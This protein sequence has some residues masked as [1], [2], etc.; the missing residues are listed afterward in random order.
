MRYTHVA[1][2]TVKP[3]QLPELLRK[4]ETELLTL[5]RDMPG[6]VAYTV[7]KTGEAAAVSFGIW[8]TKQQAEQAVKATD[9]WMKDGVGKLIDSLHNTVGELPFLAVT[10]DLGA[11]SSPALVNGIR[12]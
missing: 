2:I 10:G 1:T 5:Y 11:Y 6:F 4:A 8:H 9:K 12:A 7:A 3:G